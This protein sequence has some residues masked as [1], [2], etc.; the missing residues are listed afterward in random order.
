MAD[1]E[2]RY[3]VTAEADT[4]GLE[5]FEEALN[6]LEDKTITIRPEIQAMELEEVENRIEELEQKRA[7]IYMGV[8]DTP[9]EEVE[10]ELDELEAR[11]IELTVNADSSGL[12]EVS[13]KMDEVESKSSETSDSLNAMGG[14]IAGLGA[15][16]G[17][18][19]MITTADNINNSWNRLGLTFGSVTDDMKNNI[20][21]ASEATGRAGSTVR[22]FFNDMG[23]AGITNTQLL[24]QAFESLSGRA[25]QTGNS[26][27]SMEQKVKMMVMSGNA[28]ARQLTALGLS[29]NDLGRAMGV[30]GDEATKMFKSLSQEERLRVLTQA[31]GDGKKANDEYKNSLAGMKEQADAAFAG[32]MGAIGQAILPV[33]IPAMK[34][35]TEIIKGISGAFKE[36]PEPVRN[37]IGGFGALLLGATAVFGFLST[38]GFALKGVYDG[39]VIAKKGIDLLK[40]LSTIRNLYGGLKT[41][42][43]IIRT[44]V[45]PALLEMAATALANPYVLLAAAIIGI[46]AALWYLYN[47]N[48]EFRNSVNQLYNDLQRL[49]NGDWHV[50]VEYAQKGAD[51]AT[52]TAG[53]LAGNDLSQGLSRMLG[54]EAVDQANANLDGFLENIKSKLHEGMDAFW[55]DGTQGILGWLAE[56]AG[57]D[58]GSYLQNFTMGFNGIGASI[59]GVIMGIQGFIMNVLQIPVFIQQAVQ[60]GVANFQGFVGQVSGILSSVI[61][62]VVSFGGNF[63]SQ[64]GNSAR[65]AVSAFGSGLSGLVAEAWAEFNDVLQAIYDFGA[66]AVAAAQ[67][68]GQQIV[69]A[70]WNRHSPGIMAQATFLETK[71]SKMFLEQG[72]SDMIDIARIGSS[73][74]MNGF[75]LDLNSNIGNTG[76]NGGTQAVDGVTMNITI[77]GDVDSDERM[78]KFADY[79]I[80]RMNWDNTTAGRTV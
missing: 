34:A 61:S 69:Q 21:S 26:I 4:S 13:S 59:T 71:D 55:N 10:A 80:T 52:D 5:D 38:V 19:Q 3:K 72:L 8:D 65:N 20:N 54:D 27:E 40:D 2:I 42:A 9:L 23:I 67:N 48:E 37:V 62:N 41:L 46:V 36:L 24:S 11:K 78:E 76:S 44:N 35:L 17:L 18:E 60:Q 56:L 22:G 45:I 64:L 1:K 6:N 16:A 51:A 79:I 68:I 25:Y 70:I 7:D 39:F 47:T 12:D 49:V 29:V 43:S 14:A 33:I 31:M 57:I 50:V 28:G 63:V 32:L 15:V 73:N 77:N 30:S 58:V 53:F 66:Q 75:N 74:I